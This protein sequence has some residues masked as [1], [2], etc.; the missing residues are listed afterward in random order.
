M[1]K[2]YFWAVG[3]IVGEQLTSFLLLNLGMKV[4]Q[5]SSGGFFWSRSEWTQLDLDKPA[6]LIINL[7]F[8]LVS[9]LTDSTNI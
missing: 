5:G 4:K 3:T 6:R 1:W 7:L 2:V 8:G 9:D